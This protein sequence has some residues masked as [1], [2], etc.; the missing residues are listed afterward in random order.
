MLLFRGHVEA[1]DGS[2]DFDDARVTATEA[3]LSIKDLKRVS[4][5]PGI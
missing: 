3:L 1:A 2:G 4:E 5:R